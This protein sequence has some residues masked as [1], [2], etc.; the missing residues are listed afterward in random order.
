MSTVAVAMSVTTLLG[1]VEGAGVVVPPGSV[2]EAVTIL[3][4]NDRATITGRAETAL[5]RAAETLAQHPQ[6][7]AT[8]TGYADRAGDEDASDE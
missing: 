4:G 8:V 1:A 3:F 2:T 5:D 6:W 7:S